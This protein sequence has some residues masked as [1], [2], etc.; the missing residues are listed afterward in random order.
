MRFDWFNGRNKDVVLRETVA[1][2]AD[3]LTKEFRTGDMSAWRT[4]I[5]WKYY[6]AEAMG[7]LSQKPSYGALTVVWDQFAPWS[8][9]TAARLG[10]IPPAVPANGSE[11]W[12]GL[13]EMTPSAKIMFDASPTGGQNQFINLAGKATPHIGDQLMLHVNFQFKRVPM[14]ID[15]IQAEAESVVTLDVPPVP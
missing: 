7:K 10:L 12:N 3:E 14:T 4:P 5:F 1:R 11:Q 8:G 2:V 13:M 6:D 9:S 15:E